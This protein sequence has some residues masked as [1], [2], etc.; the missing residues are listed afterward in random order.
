MSVPA[1]TQGPRRAARREEIRRR[2]LHAVEELLREGATYSEL[3]LDRLARDA[4]ISRSRF[5]VYFEDKGD[6]L[7]ALTEDVI[8]ELFDATLPWWSMPA[9][10][11]EQDLRAV[12]RHVFEIFLPHKE[13]LA[14]VVQVA[15]YDSVTREVFASAMDEAMAGYGAR[16]AQTQLDGQADAA[17][18]P[19]RVPALLSWMAECGLFQLVAR[20]TGEDTDRH[21]SALNRIVWNVLYAGVR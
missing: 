8:K 1:R 2:L 18:D 10:S 3:P 21:L 9:G 5:Y 4:G 13:L 19:D 12:T 11:T 7:R 15:S 6:L 17:L 16:L 14:A 20:S